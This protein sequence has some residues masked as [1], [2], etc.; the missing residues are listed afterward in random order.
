MTFAGTDASLT[1]ASGGHLDT[2]LVGFAATDSLTLNAIAYGA[3]TRFTYSGTDASGVLKVTD[4]TQA[5]SVQFIGD[6]SSA[7][8]HDGAAVGGG[9]VITYG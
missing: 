4:G 7:S 5:A 8:F 1:V 6:Y 2:G 9:T 3:H